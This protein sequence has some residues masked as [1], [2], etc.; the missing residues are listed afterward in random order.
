[1][2]ILEILVEELLYLTLD[3]MSMVELNFIETLQYLGV[4]LLC[5]GDAWLINIVLSSIF[6]NYFLDFT[7]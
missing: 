4:D 5:L 3:L 2:C 7:L 1:M 6:N